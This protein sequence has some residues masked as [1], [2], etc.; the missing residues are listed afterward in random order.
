MI[1]QIWPS[2]AWLYCAVSFAVAK[3]VMKCLRPQSCRTYAPSVGRAP[4][5]VS[6]CRAAS[7]ASSPG[8]YTGRRAV[9]AVSTGAGGAA[10][11]LTTI[12][13]DRGVGGV[14][15]QR[16]GSM[17]RHRIVATLTVGR[18][19]VATQPFRRYGLSFGP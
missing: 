1:C 9:D 16:F 7:A 3:A 19:Y 18:L 5:T 6:P 10:V 4:L 12:A 15:A 14:G 11:W 13:F 2:F 17:G 8:S